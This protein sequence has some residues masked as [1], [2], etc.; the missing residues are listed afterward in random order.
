[1]NTVILS[2]GETAVQ[3]EEQVQNYASDDEE[4]RENHDEHNEEEKDD[5]SMGSIVGSDGEMETVYTKDVREMMTVYER[6]VRVKTSLE[7][8]ADILRLVCRLV[9]PT[10]KFTSE[11]TGIGT[12]DRPDFTNEASWPYIVLN[13]A[14]FN[15]HGPRTLAKVWNTYR[16]DIAD[17]FSNHRSNATLRMKKAFLA[18]KYIPITYI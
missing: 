12:F 17:V 4:S 2:R 6:K 14:G 5:D 15:A 16:K 8:R 3:E 13:K 1:M 10:E 7:T 18:G 11:G 9:L